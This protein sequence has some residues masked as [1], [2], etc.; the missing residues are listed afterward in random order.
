MIQRYW[1]VLLALSLLVVAC[2][3]G[4]SGPRHRERAQVQ[5]VN[6]REPLQPRAYFYPAENRIDYGPD[7]PKKD[8]CALLVPDH[9]FCCPDAPR[10]T[11]R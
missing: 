11:D 8:G 3:K 2:H 1:T 5:D 7:D 6:C 4:A 9:L 10:A